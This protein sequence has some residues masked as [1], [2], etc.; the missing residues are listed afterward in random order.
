MT[1]RE[2]V[3]GINGGENGSRNLLSLEQRQQHLETLKN[4]IDPQDTMV[5]IRNGEIVEIRGVVWMEGLPFYFRSQPDILRSR[6]LE[7]LEGAPYDVRLTNFFPHAPY[8]LLDCPIFLSVPLVLRSDKI[9]EL[10][11]WGIDTGNLEKNEKRLG[12]LLGRLDNV[13]VQQAKEEGTEESKGLSLV[14]SDAMEYV[15][16]VYE[17][18]SGLV[19]HQIIE[20][21]QRL[22]I[23]LEQVDGI[24]QAK[25]EEQ[26]E[27]IE[28]LKMRIIE[29]REALFSIHKAAYGIKR[30]RT[31]RNILA[32]LGVTECVIEDH[33][34]GNPETGLDALL[35]ETLASREG[36]Y[37]AFRN[38]Y[39]GSPDLRKLF[40][41]VIARYCD[42]L[43][44]RWKAGSLRLVQ[45][46]GDK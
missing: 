20:L 8:S 37:L 36:E 11:M 46:M 44:R 12:S 1:A 31:L 4:S 3:I 22:G 32:R 30:E 13:D 34:N 43:D 10:R 27:A 17:I 14:I 19:S 2:R 42:E 25:T 15:R 9:L 16:S 33:F 21:A 5:Q 26:A 24:L 18:T 40:T 39:E 41:A 23:H 28:D 45:G 7:Y 35:R 6:P 29:A 38:T